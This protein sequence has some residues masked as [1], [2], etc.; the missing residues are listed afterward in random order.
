MKGKTEILLYQ[1]EDGQTKVEVRVENETVWLTQ[2]QMVELF[3]T[4]KQNIS[5]HIRNVFQE[6]ELLEAAVVKE[7]LTTAQDGKKYKTNFYNLDVIISVGYRV[8]SHRGTQFRIW[9]TKQ[10]LPDNIRHTFNWVQATFQTSGLDYKNRCTKGPESSYPW[11]II[12]VPTRYPHFLL[13]FLLFWLTVG[14][15]EVKAQYNPPRDTVP[16][17]DS[18]RV[19]YFYLNLDSI[20]A[21]KMISYPLSNNEFRRYNPVQAVYPFYQSLGNTGQ[22]YQPMTYEIRTTTGFD[23][24]INTQDAYIFKRENLKFYRTLKPFSEVSY[25][26]GAKKE[27]VLSVSHS[28]NIYKGIIFGI[29]YNL[30]HSI[31]FYQ[32]QKSSHSDIAVKLHYSTPN[33][34]YGIAAYYFY[35]RIV[36]Y[37]NGGISADSVFTENLENNRQVVAVKLQTAEARYRESSFGFQQYFQLSALNRK[38]DDSLNI[39]QGNKLNFILGRISHELQYNKKAYAYFDSKPDTLYYRNYY[40]DSIQTYDS[41]GVSF[42]TNQIGWT[43]AS[44]YNEKEPIVRLYAGMRHSLIQIRGRDIS[45]D[46][47]Q[48]TYLGRLGLSLWPN[49]EVTGKGQFCIGDYNNLDYFVEGGLVQNVVFKS[50]KTAGIEG[51]LVIYSHDPGWYMQKYNSNHFRWDNDFGKQSGQIIAGFLNIL[52]NRTGVEIQSIRNLVIFGADT[53]PKQSSDNIGILKFS[54]SR[55][56]KL[57]NWYGSANLIFQKVSNTT[58]LKLPVFLGDVSLYYARNLFDE[59][60]FAQLGFDARYMT[61]YKAMSYE[62]SVRSFY[63]QDQIEIGNYPY[64]DVFLQF[65]IKR[66]LLFFKYEHINVLFRQYDYFSTPHYPLPDAAFKYGVRWRFND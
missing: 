11:M 3:Q 35:N 38:S 32:R 44:L 46:L 53:L 16:S 20:A 62:P 40:Y 30:I 28:Q 37:E 29:D 59:A 47:S 36:N 49:M 8:K 34:R 24:G 52:G 54:F 55:Y 17:I 41:T 14:F 12:K 27:N 61:S 57:K 9:A 65:K 7:Y 42:L 39:P 2:A 1:T 58:D 63:N 23:Y 19:Q 25:I 50:G 21:R 18:T 15:H 60:L 4:T 13:V 6:G 22:F 43:N 66:T 33:R 10:V 48:V 56:F 5:L 51:K 45:S 26:M 64:I 31:G